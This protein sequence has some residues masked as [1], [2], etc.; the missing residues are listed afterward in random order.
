[1]GECALTVITSSTFKEVLL[2]SLAEILGHF[3]EK[4]F[5]P[6]EVGEVFIDDFPLLMLLVA[7]LTEVVQ[8]VHAH[9]LLVEEAEL[10]VEQ[11]LEA[12]ATYG[13][14]FLFH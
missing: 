9:L 7:F 5:A 1:M 2:E 3:S 11:L 10:F 13:L 8:E 12:A 4:A 6:A 14:R